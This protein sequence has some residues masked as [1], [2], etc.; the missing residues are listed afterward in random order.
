MKP[1]TWPGVDHAYLSPSGTESKRSQQAAKER[2][3]RELFGNGLP[4][5]TS[6]QPAEADRLRR[7]AAQLRALAERGMNPRAYRRKADELDAQADRLE[8]DKRTEAL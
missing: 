6:E 7:E 2:T 5:P 4:H 3:R 8:E 1:G